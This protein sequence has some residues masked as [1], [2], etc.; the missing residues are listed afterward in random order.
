MG[1]KFE[2]KVI[3]RNEL[4]RTPEHEEFCRLEAAIPA[5]ARYG[6][7][8]EIANRGKYKNWIVD[9]KNGWAKITRENI[10]FM[11][12]L[13]E[14]LE[15]IRREAIVP[16]EEK[17][18][19]QIEA[20]LSEASRLD[21]RKAA[22]DRQTAIDAMCEMCLAEKPTSPTARCPDAICPLRLFCK[23]K[24]SDNAWENEPLSADEVN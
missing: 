2:D 5:S 7:R 18:G 6:L 20:E 14:D 11:R 23:A 22:H 9:R 1:M 10:L 3:R 24:L 17:T 21:A 19:E 15:A 16:K 4:L 8:Q 13:L 12:E